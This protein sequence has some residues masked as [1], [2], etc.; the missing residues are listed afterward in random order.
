MGGASKTLLATTGRGFPRSSERAHAAERPAGA[1]MWSLP[2]LVAA[3]SLHVVAHNVGAPDSRN[4]HPFWFTVDGMEGKDPTL[5]LTPGEDVTIA[6][7]N[8]GDRPH[9]LQ[10][11][12][13]IDQGTGLVE[14]N[15][16]AALSFR[17]PANVT[18]AATGYWCALHKPIGMAGA[19]SLGGAPASKAPLSESTRPDLVPAPPLAWALA[20]VALAA[21][22]RGR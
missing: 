3:L 8:A 1:R 18:T 15:G 14:P 9:Q 4:E 13:P 19:V 22:R 17:V 7:T 6:F 11:G 5:N 16:T 20:A 10:L 21:W 12:A 2:L